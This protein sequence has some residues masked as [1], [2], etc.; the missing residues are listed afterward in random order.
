[1]MAGLRVEGV[2]ISVSL[3][4][5][6]LQQVI[7]HEVRTHNLNSNDPQSLYYR[8]GYSARMHCL[9]WSRMLALLRQGLT[10]A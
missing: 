7:A 1:M 8:F 10:S 4:K 9:C 5:L 3:R 2:P 6:C